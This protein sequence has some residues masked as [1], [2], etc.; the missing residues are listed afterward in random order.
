VHHPLHCA[1]QVVRNG[2]EREKKKE[3]WIELLGV[4]FLSALTAI[5]NLSYFYDP[6]LTS[7]YHRHKFASLEEANM[8]TMVTAIWPTVC[9]QC[10]VH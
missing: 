9:K 6:Q 10:F 7:H 8:C 4:S 5:N 2:N 1:L 3:L